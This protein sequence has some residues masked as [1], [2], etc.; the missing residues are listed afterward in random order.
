MVSTTLQRLRSIPGGK[1]SSKTSSTSAPK[2]TSSKSAKP[3]AP[4]AR[5]KPAAPE[6][7]NRG[8]LPE[9]IVRRGTRHAD[10]I[11]R[12]AALVDQIKLLEEQLDP[13]REE[14]L[15][16]VQDRNG[17]ALILGNIAVDRKFRAR[18]KYSPRL[19]NEMLRI[20]NM[21]HIEQR[22]GVARNTPTEHVA[23]RTIVPLRNQESL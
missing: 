20:K 9:L 12:G 17:R 22:T 6:P 2:K 8:E 16:T 13:I 4:Q 14:L 15:K 11:K 5:T 7:I 18:W 1:T 23:F 21:Q 19:T 10:L 3:A